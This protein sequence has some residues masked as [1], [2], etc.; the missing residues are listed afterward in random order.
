MGVEVGSPFLL[1]GEKGGLKNAGVP[2]VFGPDFAIHNIFIYYFHLT[3]KV[4]IYKI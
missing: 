4:Y 2:E 1:F 3:I